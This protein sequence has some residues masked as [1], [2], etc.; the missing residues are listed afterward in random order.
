VDEADRQHVKET[1]EQGDPDRFVSVFFAP[2]ERREDLLALY[3]FD[4]EAAHIGEVGREAMAGRVRLAWW[5]EQIAT[6]Y[7]GGAAHTPTVR[8]LAHVVR[9]RLLPREFFDAS[10]D[11]R[12]LDL[13]ETPF[14]DEA[15]MAAHA[16]ATAGGIMRLACRILGAEHRADEAA[17]EAARAV[18]YLGH[19]RDLRYFAQRRRCRLPLSWLEEA[20]INA[21]DVFAAQSVTPGLRVV[22]ERVRSRLRVALTAVNGSRFPRAAMPAL[23]VA[24]LARFGYPSAGAM[25]PWQRVMRLALAN[26]TWRV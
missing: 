9:T 19:L 4:A 18:A 3:A 1:V 21:E 7:A 26:L 13:E 8:A 6:I 14:R 23:A 17:R 16:E 12:E 5:R 20:G 10:L 2:I 24:T 25:P 15:A 22:V 11:A